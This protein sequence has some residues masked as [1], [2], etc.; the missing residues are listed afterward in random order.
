MTTVRLRRDQRQTPLDRIRARRAMADAARGRRPRRRRRPP[1]Q[2]FPRGQRLRW[3]RQ[4]RA[5]V[6]AIAQAVEDELIPGLRRLVEQTE[7]ARVDAPGDDAHAMI[8]RIRTRLRSEALAADRLEAAA[9]DIGTEVS[10]FNRRQIDRQF[11]AVVG[12]GLP[13]VEP[14]I[15]DLLA[16]FTRENVRLI[17]NLGESTLDEIEGRVLSGFRRGRRHEEIAAE[18]RGR[19]GISRNRARLIARDQIAS[20]NGELTHLRHAEMGVEEYI[21]RATGDDRVRPEHEENDGRRFRWDDPPPT[22]HPGE[23]VLC[24]CVAEPVLDRLIEAL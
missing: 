8:E 13:A 21:W 19:L 24:R 16:S 15:G 6:N 3:E 23:D 4:I 18:I 10:A 12:V 5:V 11:G 14:G 1:A 2:Q 17:T 22:G 7:S 9:S 20:L